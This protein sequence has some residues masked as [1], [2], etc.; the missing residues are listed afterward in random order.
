MSRGGVT[1]SVPRRGR[2]GEGEN[3][4]LTS[5]LENTATMWTKA[6]QQ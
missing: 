4:R 1:W 2:L 3:P 5:K 6:T